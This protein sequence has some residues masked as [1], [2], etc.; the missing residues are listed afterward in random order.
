MVVHVVDR[1][2]LPRQQRRPPAEARGQRDFRVPFGQQ[3][4]T[5]D[6]VEGAVEVTAAVQQVF[7]M[8]QFAADFRHVGFADLLHQGR[9]ILIR[10]DD[11]GEHGDQT[12]IIIRH[13]LAL[14]LE[15][16]ARQE[17][18][19]A[20]GGDQQGIADLDRR[21]QGIVGMTGQDHVDAGHTGRQLAV[22]VE[23]VVRQQNDQVRPRR[24]GVGDPFFHVVFVDAERP[25]RH[26]IARV[27]DRR[28]G[29]GLADHGDLNPAL[30][31]ILD[32]LEH[33]FLPFRVAHV[34]RQE[35]EIQAVL[36]FLHPVHAIGEF[37]MRGH[38]INAQRV[39]HVD[40]VGATGLQ[41]RI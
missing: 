17:L 11:V 26:Q 32:R 37:P 6:V 15:V 28:I 10:F 25:V 14:D 33:V 34:G 27:G 4:L 21:R 31:E 16:Q 1:D 23:T 9:H 22:H 2:R 19:V 36:Q 38:R 39:L 30:V 41:R 5:D 8:A 35:R 3:G 29:K 13:L 20:A 12:E 18:A 24:L 7:R 40:H